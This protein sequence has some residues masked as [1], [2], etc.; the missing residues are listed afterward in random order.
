[1]H[2]CADEINAVMS[3]ITTVTFLVSQFLSQAIATVSQF[4]SYFYKAVKG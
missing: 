4:S 1:M 3:N 2:I